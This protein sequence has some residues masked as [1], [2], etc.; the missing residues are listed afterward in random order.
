MT[1]KETADAFAGCSIFSFFMALGLGLII[2]HFAQD[3]KCSIGGAILFGGFLFWAIAHNFE[4][5]EPVEDE[6]SGRCDPK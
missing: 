2:Q 4:P 1:E 5:D 3:L 6:C